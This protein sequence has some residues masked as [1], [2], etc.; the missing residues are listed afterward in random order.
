MNIRILLA[1]LCCVLSINISYAADEAPNQRELVNF[2]SNLSEDELRSIVS[3]QFVDK[4]NQAGVAVS[5]NVRSLI[6]AVVFSYLVRGNET[7]ME[8]SLIKKA[9]LVVLGLWG[10][11]ETLGFLGSIAR[12]AQV[13]AERESEINKL[14]EMA[15]GAKLRRNAVAS[16]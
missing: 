3:E 11:S 9:L 14:Q 12:L 7:F 2:L 5:G 4:I 8:S 10:T 15:A 1:L 6:Q 16:N 13:A